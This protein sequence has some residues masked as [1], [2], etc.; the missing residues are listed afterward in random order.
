MNHFTPEGELIERLLSLPAA[1]RSASLERACA[2]NPELKARL[3]EIIGALGA[4]DA[5]S[6]ATTLPGLSGA[7]AAKALGFALETT[8]G[9]TSGI[10]IGQYKLLQKL[11][12]GG[13]GIVWMAEQQEPIRRRVAVKIIKVGMDTEEVIARFEAE[14]QALAL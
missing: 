13:F 12:E 1:E 8:A 4:A 5:E 10:W 7:S 9:E 14:R 2:E 6:G 11:G 3:P